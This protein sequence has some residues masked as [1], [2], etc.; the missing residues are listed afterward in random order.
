[1]INL[2]CPLLLHSNKEKVNKAVDKFNAFQ[3][4]NKVAACSK[5]AEE[6]SAFGCWRRHRE[7]AE[8]HVEIREQKNDAE[9]DAADG[10]CC[11]HERLLQNE[12]AFIYA[13]AVPCHAVP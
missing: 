2:S 5:A 1:M 13:K 10:G 7:D 6:F 12:F 11:F 4:G 3:K 8:E 9:N